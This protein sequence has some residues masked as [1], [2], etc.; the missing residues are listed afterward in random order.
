MKNVLDKVKGFTVCAT[1]AGI[2]VS[3]KADM[4]L[5]CADKPAAVAASFTKNKVAAAPV[6]LGRRN[7]RAGKGLARAV[8]VNAGCANACTGPT[9]E[10]NARA[11]IASVAGGLGCRE[12]EVYM[13]S[14]GIIGVQLPM[15]KISNG[16]AALLAQKGGKGAEFT[17]AILTTDLVEKTAAVSVGGGTIAGVCK[18]SGMIA[19]NMATMLAF[20]LTDLNV[21]PPVLQKALNDAV[22]MSFNCVTVDGD[23]STNDSLLLLSSGAVGTALLDKP[24]GAAYEEFL[25]GLK[26]V[27]YSLAEQVA[28]DGEGATKLVVVNV[29]GARSD[30]DAKKAARTVAE[31][32]LVKTAMFGKDPNWGRI[33]AA[34]GRSGCVMREEVADISLCGKKIFAAGAPQE[35]SAPAL[36]K[37]MGGKEVVIDINLGLGKG[38]AQMLTCDFSYDYVKIN[39]DY[40]T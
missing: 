16:I 35:F 2:K 1:T 3:G 13:C 37:K 40:H 10:K 29:I 32:P 5:I 26:K 27:C 28:R 11:A 17:R 36:S 14:T 7:L 12:S 25:A 34:L 31:S 19:P 21:S 15:E 23:T 33:I 4:G 24:S 38:S 8:L 18:G 22:D 9:G 20:I 39:A 6:Q 30:A